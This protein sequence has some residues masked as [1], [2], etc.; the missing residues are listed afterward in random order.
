MII[1]PCMPFFLGGGYVTYLF[2]LGV[3]CGLLCKL[4]RG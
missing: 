1:L 2:L 3:V 4:V